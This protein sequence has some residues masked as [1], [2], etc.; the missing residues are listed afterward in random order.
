MPRQL[1]SEIVG[2]VAKSIIHAKP[3]LNILHIGKTG[4]TNLLEAGVGFP[5][6]NDQVKFK[7][8]EKIFWKYRTRVIG[9][10]AV[11]NS[12]SYS[13]LA[14]FIRDPLSRYESAFWYEKNWACS[15][16]ANVILQNSEVA[17]LFG[18]F[19]TFRD[20]LC[21]FTDPE[22]S[23][24]QDAWQLKKKSY[25]LH[26]DYTFYFQNSTN[27][28]KMKAN[29]VFVGET[30]DFANDLKRLCKIIG[31]KNATPLQNRRNPSNKDK[32][33][34]IKPAERDFYQSFFA[35]EY[36]LYNK[37]RGLKNFHA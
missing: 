12:L 20:W 16:Y 33:V 34:R 26:R 31:I 23:S 19:L 1:Y 24:H 2:T 27:V 18:K 14:F 21:A 5:R 25:H 6:F 3:T 9:H 37:L 15:E 17:L 10:E 4:G 7:L 30:E 11:P 35:T 36:F 13:N 28:E 22:D 29:L 32:E 8:R